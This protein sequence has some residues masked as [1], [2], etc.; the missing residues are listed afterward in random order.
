MRESQRTYL[1]VVDVKLEGTGKGGLLS[2]F[3][4]GAGTYLLAA[5]VGAGIAA[6]P[7]FASG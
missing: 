3:T 5:A 4:I 1:V 6:A 7:G 2:D